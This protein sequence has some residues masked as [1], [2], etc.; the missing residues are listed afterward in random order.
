MIAIE[1][2]T[3]E[4]LGDKLV[5]PPVIDEGK[6]FPFKF[7]FDDQVRDGM[8]YKNELYCR[9]GTVE[10]VLRVQFYQYACKLSQQ[11]SVIVTTT[12]KT[13]SIWLSLRSSTVTAQKLWNQMGLDAAGL[14]AVSPAQ[15]GDLER[16]S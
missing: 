11:E 9:L 3:A 2:A 1:L 10:R 4:F 5:L 8:S 7:W 6:V 12:G 14:Q 16:S 15:S 13:F